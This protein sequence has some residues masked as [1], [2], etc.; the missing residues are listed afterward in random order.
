VRVT[1]NIHF[2]LVE[3]ASDENVCA[4]ARAIKTMGFSQLSLVNPAT[5]PGSKTPYIAHGSHDILE[6]SRTYTSFAEAIAGHELVIGTT[7]PDRQLWQPF[8]VADDL[9]E[10]IK[11]KAPSEKTSS[12]AIVFGRECSGLTNDELSHCDIISYIP[13][14]SRFPALNLGQAIMLYAYVLQER[15]SPEAELADHEKEAAADSRQ[16]TRLREKVAACLRI[17]GISEHAKTEQKVLAHLAMMKAPEMKLV[18]HLVQR[19]ENMLK[20]Q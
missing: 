4:A 9:K 18:H 2:I 13:L 11:S 15:S 6:N 1:P 16:Y 12:I 8:V 14:A 17:L 3:P 10:F 20:P 5:P 7:R 19:L